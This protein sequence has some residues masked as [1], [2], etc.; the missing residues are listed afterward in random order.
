MA[1]GAMA[2]KSVS[3]AA[4]R[5]RRRAPPRRDVQNASKTASAACAA[6]VRPAT[7]A[8]AA[9]A[10]RRACVSSAAA[11]D[12]RA[13]AA[14]RAVEAGV[15]A[16]RRLRARAQRV[17]HTVPAQRAQQVQRHDVAGALPDRVQRH[18]A[19]DARHRAFAVLFDIAV[20][21]QAFHGFLREVAAALADP[22]LGHRREQAAHHA[23]RARR[24]AVLGAVDGA[25]QAQR[26][27]GGGFALERQVGEHVAASAAARSA[28]CR[29]PCA[30]ARGAAPATAPGASGR[31]CRARSRAASAR[32]SPGSAARR[33]LP[34]RPA[35][36]WR[37][38]TRPR[39]WRWPGCPAC[40]SGAGCG[41]R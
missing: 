2:S 11:V 18:L 8:R 31:R 15:R 28:A 14:R 37:R 35:R 1:R 26:Q 22:E 34:R 16:A 21:A 27:R 30:R 13:P 20:A 9:R 32:P 7:P 39:S 10:S 29:R 19:V 33:G 23:L 25:R 6:A 24:S 3:P 36:R 5:T 38:R 41:S 12:A 4:G 17:G 40:P